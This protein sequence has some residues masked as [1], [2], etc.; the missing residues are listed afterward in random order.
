MR[1][2]P[3]FLRFSE[4]NAVWGNREMHMHTTQTDGK[5]SIMQVLQR[6]AEVGLAEIAFTEHVRADSDWFPGFAAEVRK[7]SL[8]VPLR[9]LVGAEVRI[10]D[11]KGSLD[12]SPAIRE[13][14][15]ILLASVHR[16]PDRDGKRMSFSDV[17][18]D[19][20]AEIEFNLALGLVRKGDA[21]VLAH[22]GGMSCRWIGS[23]PDELYRAL[24]K[25]A[26]K[27]GVAVEINS[28]YI[29]DFGKFLSF[30]EEADPYVSI[31]SDAHLLSQV[32]ECRG[33]LKEFLWSR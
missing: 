1:S 16:F 14:C 27:S 8:A 12:V 31:G 5:G 13:Q 11:F 10:A 21:D 15:D 25:A 17:P 28:S 30:L 22:P 19:E 3:K 33:K 4:L 18:R 23:F 24:M 2:R 6:A 29:T 20:F 32:G 9:T 26:A 7:L